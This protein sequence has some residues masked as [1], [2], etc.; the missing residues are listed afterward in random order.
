MDAYLTGGVPCTCISS[1]QVSACKDL[2]CDGFLKGRL[3]GMLDGKHVC[4]FCS[5]VAI[6]AS[7]Y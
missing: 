6:Y 4:P 7:T 2:R 3:F 5:Q 1:K